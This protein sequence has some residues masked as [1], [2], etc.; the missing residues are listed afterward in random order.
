MIIDQITF[1]L[2]G[3]DVPVV[4]Y[5]MEIERQR[6]N[7]GMP[8]GPLTPRPIEL[9]FSKFPSE[10]LDFLDSSDLPCNCKLEYYNGNGDSCGQLDLETVFLVDYKEEWDFNEN[11]KCKLRVLLTCARMSMSRGRD[12]EIDR[13]WP[14]S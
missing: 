8:Q 2:N 9:V 5:K 12:F 4:S 10:L 14:A 3:I 11:P 1:S 6:D 7:K 13:R